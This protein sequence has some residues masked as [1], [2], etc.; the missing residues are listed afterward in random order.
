MVV[1]IFYSMIL[2]DMNYT[3]E[4]YLSQFFNIGFSCAM[5]LQTLSYMLSITLLSKICNENTRGTMFSLN[6]FVGSI[7]I[8]GYQALGGQLY[9]NVNK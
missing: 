5:G 2:I 4:T 9:S 1:I 7:A 3:N 8:I 6:G